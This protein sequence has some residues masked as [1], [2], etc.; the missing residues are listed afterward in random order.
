MA[1]L[2]QADLFNR[3]L[4]FQYFGGWLSKIQEKVK[5]LANKPPSQTEGLQDL[6]NYQRPLILFLF[7]CYSTYI[8]LQR[9][10]TLSQL[11]VNQYLEFKSSLKMNTSQINFFSPILSELIIELNPFLSNM[12]IMQ[13]Q[14]LTLVAR[15]AP[16]VSHLSVSTSLNKAMKRAH[17][18]QKRRIETYGFEEEVVSAFI[19]Y[20]DQS[21]IKIKKYRDLEQHY[22]SIIEHSF[23]QVQPEEKIVIYLPDNP[24]ERRVHNITYDNQLDALDYMEESFLDFHNF[25]EEVC[26]LLG[27]DQ[28]PLTQYMDFT[29]SKVIKGK[30]RTF[31]LLFRPI[32]GAVGHEIYH[33]REGKIVF[34]PLIPQLNRGIIK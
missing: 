11:C 24:D 8:R 25:V 3:K 32:K 10:K 19:D 14:F 2:Y 1:L 34:K 4:L 23:L 18:E 13:N 9:M 21:G 22:I 7:R 20:W 16:N 28:R 17:G 12:R 31:A 27:F 29:K 33:T 30:E 15:E 6:L 26:K 5:Q